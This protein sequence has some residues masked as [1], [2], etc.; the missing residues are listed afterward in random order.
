MKLGGK[1]KLIALGVEHGVSGSK[2]IGVL[3][4]RMYQSVRIGIG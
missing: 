3:H 4:V 2:G 1:V